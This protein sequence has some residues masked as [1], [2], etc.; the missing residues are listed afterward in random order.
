MKD[1]THLQNL[2]T[3]KQNF[4][5]PDSSIKEHIKVD[6]FSEFEGVDPGIRDA[7]NYKL[8]QIQKEAN[9]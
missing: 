5:L 8:S 2:L 9:A 7:L 4:N 6:F 3:W 1:K